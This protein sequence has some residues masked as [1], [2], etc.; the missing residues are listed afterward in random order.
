[1]DEFVAKAILDCARRLV[2][3]GKPLHAAQLYHRLLSAVPGLD[4]PYVCLSRI[5]HE[6]HR[7]AEAENVLK[8]GIQRSVD[9]ERCTTALAELYLERGAYEDVLVCLR[10]LRAKRRSVVHE[11]A[12]RALL[13]MGRLSE[14]EME[15]RMA[16]RVEHRASRAR[17]VLGNILL[18]RHRPAEAISELKQAL[19][20]DPYRGATHRLL[21][22]ALGQEH[23]WP[24]ALEEL[25]LAV[26]MDPG[27]ARAWSLCGEALLRLRR[28]A[29][30]EPYFRHALELDRAFCDAEVGLGEIALQR[31]ETE[32]ALVAFDK[33]LQLHPGHQRAL[34][35]K[36]RARVGV[37]RLA[38]Q[39]VLLLL[40]VLL[41]AFP[42]KAQD[43]G[44]QSGAEEMFR[45][46]VTLYDEGRFAEADTVFG[47]V[48]SRYPHGVQSSAATI[49]RAKAL[50]WSGKNLES[51]NVA[52]GFLSTFPS[53]IYVA[54]AHYLLGV[55]Y[56][57]IRRGE[58]AMRELLL[59][60]ETLPRPQSPRL[61]EAL[62]SVADSV[63]DQ[64]VSVAFLRSLAGTTPMRAPQAFLWLKMAERGAAVEDIK[65][66]RLAMDTLLSSYPEMAGHPRVTAL[67][68]RIAERSDVK[69]AALLPLLRKS[70]MS[71]AKEIGVDVADGIQYAVERFG[72]DPQQR[73]RVTLV[74]HD[75]EREAQL[76]ASGVRAL[77]AD[78]K[79]VAILGPVFS[80]STLAAARVA[81]ELGI[82]LISPTA[83]ANGIAAAG[84]C[85][86]QANPDYEFRGR[87]MARYAV[88]NRG[89]R[90]LAVLAPSDSYGKF[91]AQGFLDEA[92]RLGARV[93]ASEWYERGSSD[94]KTQFGAIRLAGL[95]SASDPY[96]AF[97]GRKKLGEL[98]K[99]AGLGVP[100]RVLDSLMACGALVQASTLVGPDAASRLDSLG[101]RVVYNELFL[102][103]L[104]VPVKTIDGI[105]LPIHS[106]E[107][108][109]PVSS[110]IVYFNIQAQLLGSG[111]WNNLPELD[112]SRRYCSGMVFESDTYVDVANP[113][114]A[115]WAAGFTARYKRPPS[116]HVLYGYDTAELVLEVLQEGA[117]TREAI[118]RALARVKEYQGLHA[119][120]GFSAGRVNVWVSILQFDGRGVIHVG[121]IQAE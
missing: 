13:H 113:T 93:I 56:R 1:M 15:I 120:V 20:L 8:Q 55:I 57:R 41:A 74:Q 85:V 98:M 52:R 99:L 103:S 66:S 11:C 38:G 54:D 82:P 95:R 48:L 65:A 59:A 30:A 67:L 64:D 119:R 24:L 118:I 108:I 96:I 80:N 102:D 60:W 14:A 34:D 94:F 115:S 121:D 43:D 70:E 23:C 117:T 32:C 46:G 105:Y 88:L 73:V 106:P 45:H 39:M 58:E 17:E 7:D 21:G 92:K 76:A 104:D 5:Y 47:S 110:Q 3:E 6:W 83:N 100:V 50:Y 101:I 91:L 16:L 26:D 33:A 71:A 2:E 90:S 19:R 40:L 109:G 12:A 31:G 87:A 107:E 35:G 68:G 69:I 28:Y 116:K 25:T 114:Y 72:N 42:V 111:E 77:A 112:A 37:S 84:S 81:Q 53:S 75:T 4:E 51:A 79:L 36:L 78:P 49:M 44:S 63:A 97:G 86:F 22:E 29:E 89:Y 27:D 62:Q 18:C 61:L 9:A 10:P